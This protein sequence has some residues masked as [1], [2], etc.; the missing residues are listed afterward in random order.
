MYKLSNSYQQRTGSDTHHKLKH[1]YSHHLQLLRIYHIRPTHIYSKWFTKAL[2]L[3]LFALSCAAL[4]VDTSLA[5]RFSFLFSYSSKP[6]DIR[7]WATSS[8]LSGYR[9]V[10]WSIPLLLYSTFNWSCLL[11]MSLYNASMA[12]V[13]S[14]S[15]KMKWQ[16]RKQNR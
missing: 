1:N 12:L 8:L 14:S 5:S 11:Q 7:D 4:Y 9:N 10:T 2:T 13:L 6:S 3:A 16:C 15:C